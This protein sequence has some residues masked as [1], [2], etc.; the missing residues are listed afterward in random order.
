MIEPTDEMV[1]LIYE[2]IDFH[3]HGD[4]G[5]R[6]GL[7]AVLA[8]VERDYDVK[9]RE[10]P[11][12]GLC[13]TGYAPCQGRPGCSVDPDRDAEAFRRDPSWKPS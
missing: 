1:Q 12:I 9:R 7:A 13:C 3:N 10:R 2:R 5:I 6:E 8:L 11:D 4:D